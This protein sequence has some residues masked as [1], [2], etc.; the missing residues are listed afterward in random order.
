MKTIPFSTY[1][2]PAGR[3]EVLT[4]LKNGG[5]VVF[6]SD[7]VYGLL[8]DAS[9]PDAVSKLLAFKDRPPGKAVSVFVTDLNMMEEYCEVPKEKREML[10]SMLPGSYTVVLDSKHKL[11]TR[12]ESETGTLGTR[13]IYFEPVREL[14]RKFNKPI[15]ATSANLGGHSPHYS[16]RSFL[17]DLPKKKE[18]YID[19]VVDA[20]ELPHN[21]P[22]T[23]IDFTSQELKILRLGDK[24]AKN[25]I[26][27]TSLSA[28][29][30]YDLGRGVMED[31][32]VGN[33]DKDR[34]VIVLKGDLGAGK[35]QFTKGAASYLGIDDVTSPTFVVYY[36]YD[37]V[38]CGSFKKFYHFDLYNIQNEEEFKH[39]GIE[40]ILKEKAII[41][42]E[43]GEKLGDQFELFKN[44]A[45]MELVEI[46]HVDEHTRKISI[47]TL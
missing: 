43:W 40:E 45:I 16:A 20:G 36:E 15:T 42:I 30:T 18:E 37:L 44:N 34:I 12:L 25:T 19:I 28:E 46:E 32:V 29:A 33:Y 39:L 1:Q 26:F 11:D 38:E 5:V 7:T 21:K 10:L 27:H 41:C 8:C 14:V 23:V 4:C 17:N 2:T 47:K 3:Q 24:V 13:W 6:P 35:T 22:S 9:N 31:L